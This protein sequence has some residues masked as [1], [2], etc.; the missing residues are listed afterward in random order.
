MWIGLIGTAHTLPAFG[1]LGEMYATLQ[2]SSQTERVLAF[3][4]DAEEMIQNATPPSTRS[5]STKELAATLREIRFLTV[6]T[7]MLYLGQQL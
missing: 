4:L 1:L 2:S 3:V 5:V 6:S 7:V